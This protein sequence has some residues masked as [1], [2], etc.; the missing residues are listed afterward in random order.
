MNDERFGDFSVRQWQEIKLIS[1]RIEA[2]NSL[3]NFFESNA[4]RTLVKDCEMIADVLSVDFDNSVEILLELIETEDG[5]E[6]HK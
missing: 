3:L 1:R 6:Q 4:N 2:L 5:I